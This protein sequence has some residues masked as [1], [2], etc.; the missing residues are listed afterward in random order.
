MHFLTDSHSHSHRLLR[1]LMDTGFPAMDGKRHFEPEREREGGSEGDEE[2]SHSHRLR[3]MGH[4]GREL[5]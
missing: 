2:D 5:R 1:V 3:L 4:E